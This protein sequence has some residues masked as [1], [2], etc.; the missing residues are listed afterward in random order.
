MADG[1]NFKLLKE[2]ILKLS[3]AKIWDAAKLEWRLEQV[4]DSGEHETC[5]CGHFP[6]REICVLR[7]Q[8]NG[9][10]AEVGNVCVKKFLGIRSDKVFACLKRISKNL[11][12]GLNAETIELFFGQRLISAWEREFS[13]DTMRKRSLSGNQLAK[14]KQITRTIL[15][16]SRRVR[17]QG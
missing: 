3:R 2:E 13:L 1:F 8:L 5:L 10:G 17:I 9:N 15:T 4:F 7:N 11:S 16:Q 14:R 6:I 12:A